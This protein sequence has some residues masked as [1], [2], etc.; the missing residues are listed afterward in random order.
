MPYMM[1]VA[2]STSG[3][4]LGCELLTV[5]RAV[6]DM[7]VQ[8]PAK[9]L[10]MIAKH[11]MRPGRIA[12]RTPWIFMVMEGMCKELGIEI[13]ADPELRMLTLARRDLERFTRRC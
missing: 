4:I 2:D 3:F 6:E 7:W 8:V 10:E 13:V 1:I 11:G 9:F 5:E 12:M